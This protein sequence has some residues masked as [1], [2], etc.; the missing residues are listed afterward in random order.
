MSRATRRRVSEAIVVRWTPDVAA[1]VKRRLAGAIARRRRRRQTAS[2]ALV[3]MLA[4]GIAFAFTA[5]REAWHR[6]THPGGAGP[7]RSTTRPSI[8]TPPRAP[9]GEEPAPTTAQSPESPASAGSA[10]A[11][12][13]ARARKDGVSARPRRVAIETAPNQRPETATSLLAAADAARLAGRPADAVA[14]LSALCQRF[15][16]DP[17][18]PIAAFQLGRVLA[19]EL[20][21][22]AGAAQAFERARALDPHGPLAAD[23]AARG[24]EAR[25]AAARRGPR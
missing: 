2:I 20:D 18:A 19:D 3:L 25:A 22:P 17:R 5:A 15:P 11:G 4:G 12:A 24:A 14:P 6:H 1:R 9:R 16:A 8:A 23:A 13:D 21:D 10:P 7:V